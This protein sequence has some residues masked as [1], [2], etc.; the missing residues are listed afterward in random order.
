MEVGEAV[1]PL[2]VLADEAELAEGN[3]VVLKIGQRNL[4]DATLQ[5]VGSDAGT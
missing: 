3:F 4:V 2:D 1:A 5:T